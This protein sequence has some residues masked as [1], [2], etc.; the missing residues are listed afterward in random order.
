M[1][2]ARSGNP[3]IRR[4]VFCRNNNEKKQGRNKQFFLP[5]GVS[6]KDHKRTMGS[7]Q[8]VPA[9]HIFHVLLLLLH[10]DVRVVLQGQ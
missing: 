4:F 2:P 9:A 8:I 5:S 7:D 3:K 6:S 1:H 10:S